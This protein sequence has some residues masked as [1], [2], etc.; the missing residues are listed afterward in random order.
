MMGTEPTKRCTKCG[1]ELP[2]SEFNRVKRGS[3]A[4]RPWCKRCMSEYRHERYSTGADLEEC[5][6][7]C[8]R[9]PTRENAVRSVRA[10]TRSGRLTRPSTCEGCGRTGEGQRIEAHHCDYTRPLDVIWLCPSCHRLMDRQRREREAMDRP[11]GRETADVTI[12]I[13]GEPLTV[14]AV[15]VID[16]DN[17]DL[18]TPREYAEATGQKLNTIHTKLKAGRIAGAIKNG[19]RW[20]IDPAL[21]MA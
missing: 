20:L 14:R 3:E 15:E 9:N 1:R 21:A 5:L 12:G 18:M 8:E 4:R 10:A 13:T 6:R 7:A 17:P 11:S 19:S 2:P 16:L